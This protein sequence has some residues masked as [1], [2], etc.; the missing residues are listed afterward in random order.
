MPGD[1]GGVASSV[2]NSAVTFWSYCVGSN[3]SAPKPGRVTLPEGGFDYQSASHLEFLQNQIKRFSDAQK[4]L[5]N[6]D[7]H[8]IVSGAVSA[9][10]YVGCWVLPLVTVTL[11]AGC[12]AT[13]NATVRKQYDKEYR[14]ALEDLT[15][16]YQWAMGKDT[17]NL[18]YKLGVKEVLELITTLGPWVK[19]ETIHTWNEDDLKPGKL[20]SREHFT[21]DKEV[22]LLQF[23]SGVQTTSWSYKLYGEDGVRD[24]L[25]TLKAGVS[26]QVSN[27]SE[28]V[29]ERIH[30]KRL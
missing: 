8:I 26:A 15:V 16:V 22:Q 18:W 10:G 12:W 19:A 24:A 5:Q 21:R 4:A 23:A 17:G 6:V 29:M 14:E 7:Y 27:A 13:Y 1:S 28:E 30:G 9:A 25:E 3:I 11:A 2:L 20:Y